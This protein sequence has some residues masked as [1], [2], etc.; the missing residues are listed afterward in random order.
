MVKASDVQLIDVERYNDVSQSLE[1][2]TPMKEEIVKATRRLNE[3]LLA[4]DQT[5]FWILVGTRE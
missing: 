1:L 3:L 4:D 5:L 2:P